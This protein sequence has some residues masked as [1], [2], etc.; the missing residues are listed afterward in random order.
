[1]IDR[2]TL[3]CEMYTTY[4]KAVGGKAFNGDNLPSWQEFSNDPNKQLQA[5]A[6]RIAADRALELLLQ[7]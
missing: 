2:E 6:W 7:D 1:M 4:C 3:A 5:E